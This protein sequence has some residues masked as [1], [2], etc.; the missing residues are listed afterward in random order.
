MTQDTPPDLAALAKL[1]FHPRE[2]AENAAA[3]ARAERC[4][5]S[6]LAE[7]RD[8]IGNLIARFTTALE[9]Q[10]PRTIDQARGQMLQQLDELEGERF[11]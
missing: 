8:Y 6:F 3:M 2:D 9:S 7:R 5:E 10:D 11:L 4:Y 1:K